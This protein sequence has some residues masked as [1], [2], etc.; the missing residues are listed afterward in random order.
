MASVSF[1]LFAARLV[2]LLAALLAVGCGQGEAPGEPA[3]QS[4]QLVVEKSLV[5]LPI[6]E[7]GSTTQLRIVSEHGKEL[8]SGLRPVDTLDVPLFDQA[9]PDGTYRVTAVERPCQGNCDFL[10]PPFEATRCELE[11]EVRADRT[12]RVAV[13]LSGGSA[14]PDSGCSAMTGR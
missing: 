13:V 1:P 5:G 8:V 2:I 3:R 7:E 12:T 11:V 4:G 10:D 14:G 6:F 9:V